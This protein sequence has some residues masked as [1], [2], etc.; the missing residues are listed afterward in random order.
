MEIIV[1]LQG[2]DSQGLLTLGRMQL[3]CVL[4]KAGVTSDKREGDH[5]S[6]IGIFPVRRVLFRPDRLKV[7]PLTHLPITPLSSDDGWCDDP[8]HPAYNT[9]VKLPH[10]ARCE[11]LWRDDSAYDIIVVLGH[12][13]TPPVPGLGSAIFMHV[14]LP[15]EPPATGYRGTEGCIAL[16]APDL[17]TLL[18]VCTPETRLTITP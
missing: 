11:A 12:N 8:A 7:R 14:A 4:G 3:P 6:P 15:A 9:P 10:P 13:D 5:A 1:S 2:N 18:A 17:L 16:S